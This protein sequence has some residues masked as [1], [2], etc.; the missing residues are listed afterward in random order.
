M[1]P[2]VLELVALG[3]AL[4]VERNQDACVQ[5]RELAQTLCERV[6]AEFHGFENLGVGPEGDFRSALLRGA[7]R[8][9][10]GLRLAALILLLEH[11]P[12]APDLEVEL[13]RQRIDDRYANAVQTTRDFVAVVVELAAGVQDRQNDFRRRAAA[14][15]LVGWN[16]A[17]VVDDRDR[18]IDVNRDVDLVAKP[19]QRL[20]D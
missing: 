2:S 14:H 4:V 17:A 20:V 7:G 10:I 16:P 18:S 15:V 13:L 8:L 12:V 3:F 19:G 5:E 9:E 11:L 1:P 6:E